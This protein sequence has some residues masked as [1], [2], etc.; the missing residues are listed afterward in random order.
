MTYAERYNIVANE[1]ADME[2]RLFREH[3]TLSVYERNGW[4]FEADGLRGAISGHEA[5]LQSLRRQLN[6]LDWA[7][8]KERYYDKKRMGT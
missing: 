7:M 5:K 8:R 6:D 4:V 3:R 1:F 2:E